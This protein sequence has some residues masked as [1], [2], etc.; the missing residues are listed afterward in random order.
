MVKMQHMLVFLPIAVCSCATRAYVW[1]VTGEHVEASRGTN[2]HG[3]V[4][5][6]GG[7]NC[8]NDT[9][10]GDQGDLVLVSYDRRVSR[11]WRYALPDPEDI[12][13]AYLKWD[14]VRWCQSYCLLLESNGQLYLLRPAGGARQPEGYRGDQPTGFPLTPVQ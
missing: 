11:P 10:M 2:D 7:C 5:V 6:R 4:I 14:A 13:A 9:F 3:T 12:P 8:V 1:N